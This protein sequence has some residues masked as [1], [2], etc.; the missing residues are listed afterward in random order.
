MSARFTV[1][2]VPEL[3]D[4]LAKRWLASPAHGRKRLTQISNRIDRDLRFSPARRGIEGAERPGFRLWRILDV[5]PP[6]LA[7]FEVRPNNLIV[8]IVQILLFEK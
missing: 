8:E 4:G 3:W 2:W 5:E 7:V 6:A 1:T